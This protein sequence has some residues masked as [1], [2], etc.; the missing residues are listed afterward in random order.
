MR[1]AEFQPLSGRHARNENGPLAHSKR[2]T[3]IKRGQHPLADR[4]SVTQGDDKGLSLRVCLRVRY[5][6]SQRRRVPARLRHGPG[7]H[8]VEAADRALPVRA[9]T[10]LAEA[11][12]A[13]VDGDRLAWRRRCSGLERR[14]P[15]ALT[16]HNCP[17]RTWPRK[18][19]WCPAGA[20]R[21]SGLVHILL[22]VIGQRPNRA[23]ICPTSG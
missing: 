17:G 7:G 10:G 21:V 22:D 15:P 11:G 8:R 2:A 9:V 16:A 18:P 13:R 19:R 5:Q 6:A 3:D 20:F 14:S 4:R 12:P 23:V 1:H